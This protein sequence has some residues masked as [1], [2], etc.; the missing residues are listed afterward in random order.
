MQDT[1]QT[2]LGTLA[3]LMGPYMIAI[4]VLVIALIMG[5]TYWL[6]KTKRVQKWVYP[7]PEIELDASKPLR[8]AV[9]EA[10]A[11]NPDAPLNLVLDGA[12][13]SADEGLKFNSSFSLKG[14]GADQTRIVSANN[15][16]AIKV[17]NAKNCSIEGVR[18]QGS[19]QCQNGELLMENCHID[20]NQDGV[21]IEA[22]DGSVVT[23]SGTINTEGGIAIHARGESTIILKPPYRIS[24]D[25]Y[26]VV[27]PKSKL[28]LNKESP[29][30]PPPPS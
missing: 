28:S 29:P 11:K 26:I 9:E 25:D 7:A 14:Q 20:A 19:I 10:L 3:S 13:Y 23:F 16:S 24:P 30:S 17:E 4:Q 1:M 6:I 15:Q 5:V 18:I 8:Q 22:F 2:S 27:D 12:T 21:C